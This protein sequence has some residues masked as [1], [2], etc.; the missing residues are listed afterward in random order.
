MQQS[1][2]PSGVLLPFYVIEVEIKS[3]TETKRGRENVWDRT[4]Y[5]Q[6]F[7]R[8]HGSTTEREELV[9]GLVSSY[10]RLVVSSMRCHRCGEEGHKAMDCHLPRTVRLSYQY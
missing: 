8:R 7:E 3:Q 4:E 2:L 10:S 6:C 5:G 1:L 9:D